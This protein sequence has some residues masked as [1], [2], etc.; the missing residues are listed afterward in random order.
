[1]SY[2]GKAMDIIYTPKMHKEI[3]NANISGKL[4]PEKK[5]RKKFIT[6]ISSKNAGLLMIKSVVYVTGNC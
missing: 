2:N 6:H 3:N 5:F 1:M 4:L